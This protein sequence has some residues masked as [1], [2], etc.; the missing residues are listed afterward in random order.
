M[1]GAQRLTCSSRWAESSQCSS[2]SQ[3][4]QILC[5]VML[6]VPDTIDNKRLTAHFFSLA[7]EFSIAK[8]IQKNCLLS[9]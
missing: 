6:Q 7:I 4:L 8:A 9:A 3:V 1:T 5:S 2:T